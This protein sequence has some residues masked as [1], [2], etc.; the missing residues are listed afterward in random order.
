MGQQKSIFFDPLN[1]KQNIYHKIQN[2]VWAHGLDG[3]EFCEKD[4]AV[5]DA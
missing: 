3:N 5:S 4:V 1:I 2:Q